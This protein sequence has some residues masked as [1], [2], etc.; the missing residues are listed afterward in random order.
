[1]IS[2]EPLVSD[3]ELQ[4]LENRLMVALSRD[5]SVE[6]RQG[7][8]SRKSSKEDVYSMNPHAVK[9]AFSDQ[10]SNENHTKGNPSRSAGI[11][12]NA[13]FASSSK[14]QRRRFKKVHFVAQKKASKLWWRFDPFDYRDAN[15]Q[16]WKLFMLLPLAY[17]VWAFPYRL[18]L[19]VPSIR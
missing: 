16:R 14:Q 19:G 5:G 18:A 12:L 2:N 7:M 13:Q 17:E 9:I 11:L 1:M 15:I 6:P 3:N 8:G 10:K 4:Q